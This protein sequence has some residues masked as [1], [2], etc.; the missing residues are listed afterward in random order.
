MNGGDNNNS[1]NKMRGDG[2]NSINDTMRGGDRNS[3]NMN[4]DWEDADN[5]GTMYNYFLLYFFNSI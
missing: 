5:N 1:N 2:R 3:M 4:M